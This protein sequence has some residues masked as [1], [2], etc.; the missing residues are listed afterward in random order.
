MK[1]DYKELIEKGFL[2]KEEIGID[3][4][5]KVLEKSQRNLKSAKILLESNEDDIAFELS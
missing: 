3:K 5:I 4:I 1:E 2:K